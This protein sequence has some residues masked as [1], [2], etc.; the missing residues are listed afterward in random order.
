MSR[1][2]RSRRLA[3]CLR[4]SGMLV[5]APA[6]VA[7]QGIES[8]LRCREVRS[9]LPQMGLYS[10]FV[11]GSRHT[12]VAPSTD[13]DGTIAPCLRVGSVFVGASREHVEHHLGT[14]WRSLEP[15]DSSRQMV[16]YRPSGDS[17]I[18]RETYFVVEYERVSGTEVVFSVQHTGSHRS[19]S[20]EM[21]CLGLGDSATVVRRQLGPPSDSSVFGK[22]EHG[23]SGV[24]WY[25]SA[26]PLSIELV[27][28][29]VYSLRVWRSDE[30]AARVRSLSRLSAPK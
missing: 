6:L 12:C 27:D 10:L 17:L 3:R 14:P 8:A 24:S 23:S 5:G 19:S 28:G 18:A 1:W 7:A 11:D 9:G 13:A 26:S 16:A 21:S 2:S 20:H 25:Y 30:I 29:R 22:S 4:M 15:R